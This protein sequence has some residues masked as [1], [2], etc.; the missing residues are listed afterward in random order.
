MEVKNATDGQWLWA[1]Y[2]N[3][4]IESETNKYRLHVTGYHG[5]AEDALNNAHNGDNWKA[6]G[7]PFSTPDVD[8]DL[9]RNGNCARKRGWWFGWCST[10]CLNGGHPKWYVTNVVMPVSQSRMMLRCGAV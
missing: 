8:N 6:N 1:E 10:S 4:T 2:D 5:N 9:N 7:M 3:M